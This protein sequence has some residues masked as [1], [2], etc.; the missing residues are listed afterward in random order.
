MGGARLYRACVDWRRGEHPLRIL[1]LHRVIDTGGP[2][3]EA[4]RRD[5]ARGCLSL[6]AFERR[7]RYLRRR[8]T[9]VHLDDCLRELAAGR[10]LPP[11]ALALTFD[12]GHG[13]VGAN[14]FPVLQT[15]G[16]PF[17]VFVTT[18]F[19]D[20]PGMLRRARIAEMAALGAGLI[21]WGAHGVTHRAL[22]D[23]PA[24][25]AEE[26]IVRSKLALEAMVG[27]TVSLFSY[28]DG[29]CDATLRATVA[30][31]GFVGACATGRTVNWAPVDRFALQRIPCE[32]ES[33]ARFAFR[34]AGRV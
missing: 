34:V 19:V 9:I 14:V 12:D 17:A 23:L 29:K 16:V 21:A 11:Y 20:R 26:E 6:S 22:T 5:L 7:I 15:L 18:G 25:E 24:R 32:S 3:N 2:L 4:D 27:A 31:Q 10:P 8:Y 30:R 13:D 1:S 33:L 28:P